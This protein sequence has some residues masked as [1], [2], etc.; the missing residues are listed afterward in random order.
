ME[1]EGLADMMAALDAL[2]AQLHHTRLVLGAHLKAA[3]IAAGPA[4][5]A[6]LV[7]EVERVKREPPKPEAPDHLEQLL[8][9]ARRHLQVASWRLESIEP[10]IE[11]WVAEDHPPQEARCDLLA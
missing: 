3:E 11:R 9:E 4:R 10:L 8:A 1:Q 5:Q 2:D 7:E 6:R